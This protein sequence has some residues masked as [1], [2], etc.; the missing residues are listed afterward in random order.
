MTVAA[1]RAER[2]VYAQAPAIRARGERMTG[3]AG[4]GAVRTVE[5]IAGPRVIERRKREGVGHVALVTGPSL[6]LPAVRVEGRVTGEAVLLH[7]PELQRLL[8]D[9]GVLVA[10]QAR[11]GQVGAAEPVARVPVVARDVL[12][13]RIPRRVR[14]TVRAVGSPWAVGEGAG[15]RVLVTGTTP[16]GNRNGISA[17]AGRGRKRQ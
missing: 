14:V 8:A 9:R 6:E 13:R 3:R 17:G 7:D 5:W 11:R 16:L 15:V 4:N 2:P 1:C 12:A 10:G